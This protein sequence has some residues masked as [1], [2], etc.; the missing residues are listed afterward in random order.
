MGNF[1]HGLFIQ[2]ARVVIVRVVVDLI[3]FTP[4]QF[5]LLFIL[6]INQPFVGESNV[7]I[8][9]V[10]FLFNKLKVMAVANKSDIFGVFHVILG[11][12]AWRN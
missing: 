1:L 7:N 4:E 12:S 5:L 6:F 8:T 11:M 10:R 2:F 9:G 3:R